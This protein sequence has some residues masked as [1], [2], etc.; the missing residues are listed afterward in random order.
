MLNWQRSINFSP[1]CGS[2]VSQQRICRLARCYN[3]D[4]TLE[5]ACPLLC[6]YI[7]SNPIHDQNVTSAL[8]KRAVGV[9][10]AYTHFT[11][12]PSH[13]DIL[14]L[15]RHNVFESSPH[16]FDQLLFPDSSRL[17]HAGQLF[18]HAESGCKCIYWFGRLGIQVSVHRLL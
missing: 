6:I 7:S 14:P 16:V 12:M 2:C 18:K 9:W 13:A 11:R 5:E 15:M 8:N 1:P 3:Y 17:P 4:M 10:G